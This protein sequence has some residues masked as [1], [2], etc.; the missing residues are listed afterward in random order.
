[1]ESKNHAR[2][3][4]PPGR[5]MYAGSGTY[6]VSKDEDDEITSPGNPSL[7]QGQQFFSVFD[8]LS[9]GDK[10]R[11]IALTV[12]FSV[13]HPDDRGVIVSAAERMAGI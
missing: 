2:N 10:Q 7:I 12:A 8:N 13:M 3:L 5:E 6:K 9:S 11:L 1:M 4:T